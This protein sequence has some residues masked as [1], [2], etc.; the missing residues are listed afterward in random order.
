ME[1][2]I[3]VLVAG[4]SITLAWVV[5]RLGM[6][7][8]KETRLCLRSAGCKL[9]VSQT[10]RRRGQILPAARPPD[11]TGD[12]PVG[13]PDEGASPPERGKAQDDK[14]TYPNIDYDRMYQ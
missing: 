8:T 12:R 14:A 4:T 10:I 7:S 1:P 9:T 6:P 3:L 2:Q 5:L 11:S 13:G